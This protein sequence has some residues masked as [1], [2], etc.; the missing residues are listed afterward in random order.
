M[1]KDSGKCG[2][3]GR[4]FLISFDHENNRCQYWDESKMRIVPEPLANIR[5]CPFCGSPAELRQGHLIMCM[6]DV[7]AVD[8]LHS[9]PNDVEVIAEWNS[10]PLEMAYLVEALALGEAL[11]RV[12]HFLESGAG[13][14]DSIAEDIRKTLDIGNA[15]R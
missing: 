9:A 8:P 11:Y 10:R 14:K 5:P 1:V 3:Y 7:C 2:R 4:E 13:D 15:G 12:L 6:N